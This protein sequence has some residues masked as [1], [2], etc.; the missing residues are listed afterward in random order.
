[1]G[2]LGSCGVEVRFG[3]WTLNRWM[4]PLGHFVSSPPQF[5][6][7]AGLRRCTMQQRDE[8]LD[9]SPPGTQLISILSQLNSL[10]I[11]AQYLTFFHLL[12]LQF[13]RI[14]PFTQNPNPLR[15]G[16]H[17]QDD[18]ALI[19]VVAGHKQTPTRG[20]PGR[21]RQTDAVAV[22]QAIGRAAARVGV[23]PDILVPSP[24]V[25]GSHR[26]IT[27][28]SQLGKGDLNHLEARRRLP[29]PRSVLWEGIGGQR[30][31]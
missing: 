16:R 17:Q 18:L 4:D 9:I 5:R 29:V 1:M 26:I 28:I 22:G 8:Q 24:A 15:L 31:V 13:I 20:I 23:A 14:P 2:G 25:G 27:P 12:Q 19:A 10:G 6:D 3:V 21:R 7:L 30:L 11:Q